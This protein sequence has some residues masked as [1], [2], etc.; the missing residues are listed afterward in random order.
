MLQPRPPS[1]PPCHRLCQLLRGSQLGWVAWGCRPP[2]QG[3]LTATLA[4]F[5]PA[6]WL[7]LPLS[8]LPAVRPVPCHHPCHTRPSQEEA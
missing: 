4:G 5:A 8:L 3:G 6:G 2:A 7:F 1:F